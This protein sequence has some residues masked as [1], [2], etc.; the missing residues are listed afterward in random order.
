MQQLRFPARCHRYAAIQTVI[1]SAVSWLHS[2]SHFLVSQIVPAVPDTL[3]PGTGMAVI[4]HFYGDTSG[5]IYLDTLALT[6]EN[7]TIWSGGKFTPMSNGSG[8]FYV[9]FKGY[10]NA[11]PASVP[12]AAIPNSLELLL[13]PNPSEG[14]VNIELEGATN[15]TYEVMDILGHVIASHTG[16]GLWQWDPTSSALGSDGTYF[17]RAF[18]ADASGSSLVTTKRLVLKR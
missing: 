5:T 12:I 1:V 14:I 9:N 10:S 4:I 3:A 11:A 15:A 16:S 7:S 8:M 13:Y 6:I 2:S 17:I 18:S